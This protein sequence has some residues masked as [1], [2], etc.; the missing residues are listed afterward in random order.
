MSEQKKKRILIIGITGGLAQILARLILKKSDEYEVLGIDSRNTKDCPQINGLEYLTMRYSRGNFENLF[1]SYNFDVV[2]HLARISHSANSNEAISKRLDLNLMGTNRILNLCLRFHV[3]KVI[4]LSTFHVYGA[5]ADNSVFLPETAPLKA[6][7]HYAEL[8]D[9]V[10]MD[11]ICTNWIWQHQKDLETIVLRPCN[12]IG[13][14]INNAISKFLTSPVTL[15][16]I[17]Y[18]PSYQFI[19]EFDMATI[20]FR[21]I[22]ELPLGVYNVSPDDYITLKEALARTEGKKIPFPV[23]LGKFV[24]K[25]ISHFGIYIPD[26]FIDYL[27]YTCLIDN[28]QLKK[29]LGN[30]LCRF[31][32]Q[33]TLDLVSM[34]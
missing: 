17:D 29:H 18:N 24:N 14:Q 1:R 12:I 23:S 21:S 3:S 25:A 7:I 16:P 9:V 2:Y 27:K 15:M 10:E 32:V 20:L 34:R 22:K 30:D 33:E 11:Q 8:R 5:L 31:S 26:Y 6:S 13:T 19:H 4:I 28:S